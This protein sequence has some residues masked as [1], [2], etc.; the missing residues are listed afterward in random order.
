[1][2][3]KAKE[4]SRPAAESPSPLAMVRRAISFGIFATVAYCVFTVPVS[5]NVAEK[6][7][8]LH[9]VFMTLFATAAFPEL[10][11]TIGALAN[12]KGRKSALV[13]RH[14]KAS[15]LLQISG[16]VGFGAA[17]YAKSLNQK[18]HLTT[19]HAMGGMA[20]GACLMVEGTLG[21]MLRYVLPAGGSI[22]STVLLLHKVTSLMVAITLLITFSGGML[23]TEFA[24]RVLPSFAVRAAIA[25]SVPILAVMARVVG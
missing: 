1:M 21:A 5:D 8:R 19:P 11:S 2:S 22:R 18:A 13:D 6:V 3:P 23:G 9:P 10:M 4:G 7:F 17:I 12:K 15:F 25:C 24:E 20:C 14:Q 16:A